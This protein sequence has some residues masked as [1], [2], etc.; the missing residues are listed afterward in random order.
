VWVRERQAA[1]G[2]QDEMAREEVSGNGVDAVVALAVDAAGAGE[3]QATSGE[4]RSGRDKLRITSARQDA[5]AVCPSYPLVPVKDAWNDGAM[6]VSQSTKK[7]P[8][9]L[10][11]DEAGHLKIPE[12]PRAGIKKPPLS[13]EAAYW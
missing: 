8:E 13:V 3:R 4:I 2:R 6:I 11:I 9:P 10:L 12:K 5:C 1:S 7:G